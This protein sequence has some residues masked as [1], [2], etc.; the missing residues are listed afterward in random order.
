MFKFLKYILLLLVFAGC[1]S[2]QPILSSSATILLKTPT[3][4]FYDKGFI[5]KFKNY[6]QVQIFSAGT[7]ILNLDIYKDKI[8]KSTLECISSK[9]FNKEN[10]DTSYSDDF[11]KIL[12]DKND[13]R[14]VF[15]DKSKGILIKITR[16]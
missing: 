4:K 8:C 11:L 1:A 9:S 6:T 7:M 16:D 2:K 15:R 10:L 13:K 14:V 5:S 3:M 12:F